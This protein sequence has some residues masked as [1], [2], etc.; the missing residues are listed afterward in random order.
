MAR[1]PY[2]ASTSSLCLSWPDEQKQNAVGSIVKWYKSAHN[3]TI[4]TERVHFFDDRHK[5][6]LPF[7]DYNA[8]FGTQFNARMISCGTRDSTMGDATGDCGAH[9]TEIDAANEDHG[10]VVQLCPAAQVVV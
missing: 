1:W 7:T 2:F 3:I 10:S 5:N 4:P 9:I 6:I 8:Q